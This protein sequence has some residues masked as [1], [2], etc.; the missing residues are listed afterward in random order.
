MDRNAI[1][2]HN[3]NCLEPWSVLFI[4]FNMPEGPGQVFGH[5]C[6]KMTNLPLVVSLSYRYPPFWVVLVFTAMYSS[7]LQNLWLIDQEFCASVIW[8]QKI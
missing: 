8:P 6:P 1:Q 2:R 4:L 5:C 3:S 7:N